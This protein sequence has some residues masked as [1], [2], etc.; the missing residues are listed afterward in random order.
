VQFGVVW[1]IVANSRSIQLWQHFSLNQTYIV[2]SYA[3]SAQ[4]M[5]C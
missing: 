3:D 1:Y 5:N 4:S 2:W